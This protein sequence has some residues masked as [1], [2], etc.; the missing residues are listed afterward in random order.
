ML[1]FLRVHDS[2]PPL[3]Y[4][5]RLPLARLGASDLVLRAP[6]LVV[7]ISAL[8]LFAW[9]MRSRGWVGVLATAL[10]AVS[11]FQIVYGGE[12]RMYALLQLLGVAIAIVAES[13]LRRPAS[14]HAWA[15]GALLL[16][17][18]LDHV[19]GFLLGAGLLLVAG[20]RRDVAAWRWRG[21]VVGAG[22]VWLA[23]WGSSFVEQ[24]HGSDTSWIPRTTPTGFM[25]VVARH[26]TFT[27]AL[28]PLVFLAIVAGGV[29]LVRSDR[30]IGRLWWCLGAVPFVLAGFLGIFS[31]FLFDRTLTLS[32]WAAPIAVAVMVREAWKRSRLIGKALAVM[33]VAA[34]L[35]SSV[36]FLRKP[37]A[38]D[39][40]IARLEQV[41]RP[42]DVV[43][44]Y[45]ARFGALVGWR[46]GVRGEL[47]AA[48]VTLT[49]L[50]ESD[51]WLVGHG[52][53]DRVW[54]LVWLDPHHVFAGLDRCA[55]TWEDVR[56]RILC[57]RTSVR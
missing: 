6:S 53:S 12:A 29:V 54:V 21:G 16:V 22:A 20:T 11:I 28:A 5:L 56:T 3:D 57:L 15:L 30:V 38:S 19:S 42:G 44:S 39:R 43:A 25:R 14:W 32:S 55:P 37:W 9:W 49:G 52:R 18:L 45:P 40:D 4:L 7:S 23:L 34:A 2:H 27:E 10:M 24:L 48:P 13:W 41:V 17:A 33:V 31:S 46:I 8:A 50:P 36:S 35:A 47:P 26:V 51:A 1:D